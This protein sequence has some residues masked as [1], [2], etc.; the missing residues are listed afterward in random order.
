M[1]G[2]IGWWENST[3]V[4]DWM[5]RPENKKE[6]MADITRFMATYRFEYF[7]ANKITTDNCIKAD[8][9]IPADNYH[10][11]YRSYEVVV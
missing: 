10:I 9:V 11:A 7:D 5:S 4:T 2:K 8:N 6:V 3:R 1:D